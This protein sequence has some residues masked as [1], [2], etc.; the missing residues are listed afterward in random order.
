M[1][2]KGG[3]LSTGGGVCPCACVVASDRERVGQ[4]CRY[5]SGD[6]WNTCAEG[7]E[8]S[9]LGRRT[10]VRPHPPDAR[11]RP[12]DARPR[13]PGDSPACRLERGHAG[14]R[15]CRASGRRSGTSRLGARG[16]SPGESGAM[17][18]RRSYVPERVS[19]QDRSACWGTQAEVLDSSLRHACGQHARNLQNGLVCAAPDRKGKRKSWENAR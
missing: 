16:A 2:L 5:L 15:H 7:G 3:C 14:H 11:P 13:P 12:P 1:T 6:G 18:S 17:P 19:W 8:W 10:D 4:A 9:P